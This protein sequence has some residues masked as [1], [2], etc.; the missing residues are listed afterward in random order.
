MPAAYGGFNGGV[1]EAQTRAPSREMR[2]RV[3]YQMTR[4]EWTEFHIHENDEEN[5]R[6]SSSH[7][8]QPA[9]SKTV[10]RG[11]LEG[12]L[13]ENFGLLANF[14]QKRSTIPLSMY[15][16]HHVEAVGFHEVEQTR[17]IDNYYLKGV[18]RASDAWSLESSIAYAPEENR[19]YRANQANS[20]FDIQLGGLQAN[21]KAIWSGDIVRVEQN[22]A[23]GQQEQTRISDAASQYSWR[24]SQSKNW[25]APNSN[26][27]SRLS[28]EGG[29]G[30]VE[31]QQDSWQYRL[32]ADW[33]PVLIGSARHSVQTG[34][35]LGYQDIDY[36]RLKDSYIY[37]LPK[38]T[39]TCINSQSITDTETCALGTTSSGWPGQFLS[40]AT[41]Y[42]QGSFDVQTTSWGLWLQDEI[43]LGK[44]TLRPGV[45]ADGDDYMD[46]VTL[47]PRFALTYDL[48]ADGTTLFSAGANRYYGRSAAAWQLEDGRNRLRSSL[49]RANL[50]AGWVEGATSA[51]LVKFNQLDIAYDDELM[52]GLTQ[53][54]SGVE[55]G[56]KYVNR[57]GRDQVVQVKGSVIGQ[58]STNPAELSNN[59]TTYTN[60]GRSDAHVVS[61]T[62][63]PMAPVMLASTRSELQLALDWTKVS[64]NHADYTETLSETYYAAPYIRYDG[65]FMRYSER[66][67]SNFARPWTAR[68]SSVTEISPLNL[69]LSN[70]WRYRAGYQDIARVRNT[71]ADYQ[72]VPVEVWEKT[73]YDAA[74]TWDLR[75][76]W[77]LPTARN[78][79]FFVNVDVFNVLNEK[80]VNGAQTTTLATT[81]SYDTGRQYWLEVGYRF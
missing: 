62:A 2:G 71:T 14:S 55:F 49:T 10:L 1:I 6:Y 33:T 29:Y 37:V 60:D 16:P 3:S 40:S 52:V 59:Y 79:A 38:T 51:N 81:P 13:T 43:Q 80:S 27:N 31:Q 69:N 70:F 4:S 5:F 47:A 58:P 26:A 36:E 74:L 12:H 65:E 23:W 50:N 9:F 11:T 45:R 73:S 34:F 17:G 20:G 28:I 15:S 77:E 32:N 76:G 63:T 35:E 19:Y 41:R 66:P 21:L 24:Y 44:L 75:L 22:L 18:W 46:Q 57:N 25:G 61:F 67:A 48:F 78:Q 68:L 30:D 56:L 54:W 7:D 39:G 53:Q 72:G 42:R 64:S 8:E